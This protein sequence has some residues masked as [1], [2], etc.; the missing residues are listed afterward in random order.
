MEKSYGAALRPQM[1]LKLLLLRFRTVIALLVIIVIFTILSNTFLTLQN[2]LLMTRHVAIN[3]FLAIGMTLVIVSGGIDLSVGSILGLCGMIVGY[4]IDAGLPLHLFGVVV[5]FHTWFIMIIAIAAG[6][7]IG[8]ANGLIITRLN[9]APFIATLGMLY[10]ARGMAL[11][12]NN[13]ST[14]PFLSGQKGLGNTGFPF[15]GEGDILGVPVPI[16][17]LVVV[18]LIAAFVAS[19]TP[20]G[21]HIYAVGGNER[22]ARLSGVRVN[23]IRFYVYVI[24]GALAALSGLIVTSQLVAAHPASGETYELNAIAA[25]VLGGTS[26]MGGRG[27]IGGT[28]IGSFVIGILADGLVMVGVS[29]FWQMVIKGLVIIV[30]V[31]IDQL[32]VNISRVAAIQ[33]ERRG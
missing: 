28:I 26:L 3:A 18:A 4:L 20:F 7:L 29:D 13:G 23:A 19:R 32:Q 27:T 11:L 6:A 15:L 14:F 21:R 17:L 9:V 16:W 33:E 8:S 12:S 30:A 10:V 1:N 31:A 24:S 5:Y 22:A 25:A 2:I